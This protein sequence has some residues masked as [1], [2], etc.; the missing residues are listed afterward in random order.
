M[1]TV[2]T[3]DQVAA[4]GRLMRE[5]PDPCY[6]LADICDLALSLMDELAANARAVQANDAADSERWRATLADVERLTKER[7]TNAR[8]K[9]AAE[10]EVGRLRELVQR[11]LS[12]ANHAHACSWSPRRP[13]HYCTCGMRDYIE[14]SRDALASSPDTEQAG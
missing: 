6:P 12:F 7:D 14:A 4:M 8:A 11:S 10:A 3:R 13:H 1:S 5:Q 9:E 2:P